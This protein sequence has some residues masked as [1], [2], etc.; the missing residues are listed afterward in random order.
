MK[1]KI[2]A[3]L[4]VLT[5]VTQG[6]MPVFAQDESA[7]RVET[8]VDAETIKIL[9]KEYLSEEKQIQ[10]IEQRFSIPQEDV[11]FVKGLG[12]GTITLS[13]K[14]GSTNLQ[15]LAA[16]NGS[17]HTNHYM[18]LYISG[19]NKIGFEFR[20]NETVND[21]KNFT[22]NDVNL[23]DNQWH[24]I[25]LVT[26][27]D[28]YYKVYLDQKLVQQWDVSETNFVDKMEWEPTSVTFGGAN[29]ISGN[30]YPFTGSIKEVKLYNGAVSEDQIMADHG[31]VSV[32]TP[33]F[34]YQRKMFDGTEGKMIQLP[35]QK[36]KISGLTKGTFS[37]A[38]RLNEAAVGKTIYGLLSLSNSN[39]DREY[40]AL[41][42]KPKDNRIGYEVQGKG[43]KYITVRNGNSVNNAES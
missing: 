3:A 37:F 5:M 30:S 10:G 19:G 29:R 31:A 27:K 4:L 2:V 39:A 35:E 32:G 40:G 17:T 14:T 24:T 28:S 8:T 20:K 26:E 43:D 25:T 15:V 33:I 36:E 13:F 12:S 16:I 1:K 38:Y 11:A 6:A 22:V 34:T 41:Y 18:S 7:G 21:H 9:C 42:I 23:A